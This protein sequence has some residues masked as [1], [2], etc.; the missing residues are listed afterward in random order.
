[1]IRL[2]RKGIP[3]KEK[4]GVVIEKSTAEIPTAGAGDPGEPTLTPL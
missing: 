3:I 4:A 2:A 1:M